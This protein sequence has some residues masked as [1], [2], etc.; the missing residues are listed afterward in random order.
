MPLRRSCEE[1]EIEVAKIVDPASSR[2]QTKSLWRSTVIR[3]Q[4]LRDQLQKQWMELVGP[5]LYSI[6]LP[7][8]NEQ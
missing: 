4:S 1:K 5:T 2:R 8:L 7:A 3:A 6:S